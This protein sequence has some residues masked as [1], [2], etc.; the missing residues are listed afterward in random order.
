MT[1]QS[2]H[3]HSINYNLCAAM[4][5]K[6]RATS[7]SSY[8]KIKISKNCKIITL[9]A[10]NISIVLVLVP[11][12]RRL[13]QTATL[14]STQ[15]HQS[16]ATI[17]YDKQKRLRRPQQNIPLPSRDSAVPYIGEELFNKKY[18]YTYKG[19]MPSSKRVM[20]DPSCGKRPD[21]FAFFTLPKTERCV[22]DILCECNALCA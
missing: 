17:L 15:D 2:R 14:S 1:Q 21:F 18:A 13:L 9:L 10:C 8:S 5:I 20:S 6:S 16:P 19:L 12:Y 7:S 11:I 22:D 3:T 4:K